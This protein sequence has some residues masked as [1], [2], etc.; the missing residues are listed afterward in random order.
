[1][2][3]EHTPRGSV[4]LPTA[5]LLEVSGLTV[6]FRNDVRA[7]GGP[8]RAVRGVG[9]R[10]AA[11]Q[12]MAVVGPSGS[13]KSVTASALIGLVPGAAEVEG[14]VR[15]D[16]QELLHLSDREL[17]RIRGRR[18]GMVFQ[19]PLAALNP[20]IP[21]GR[22]IAEAVRLHRTTTRKEARE[23]AVRL[24]DRV[25][26]PSAARRAGAFPH[27]FSGGMR[28]RAAIAMAIAGGPELL[29]ADEPTSALD[30]TVQA[31]LLHLLDSLRADTGCALLMITHDLGVVA[32]SCDRIA[33]MRD[34][35]LVQQ[36]E[37]ATLLAAASPPDGELGELLTA[38]RQMAR[39]R[40]AG[41]R[42]RT[43]APDVLR[44]EGLRREYPARGLA[45]AGRRDGVR[46][47]DGVSFTVAEGRALALLGESG[48]GK[49]TVLREI[50]GLRPPQAGRVEVL[51]HDLATLNRSDRSA[52]RRRMQLVFQDP[53]SSLDPLMTVADL[54]GEPLALGGEPAEAR[55]RRVAE[56][57]DLVELEQAVA[58]ARPGRLSGGQR[59]RVAIAR[60]LATRPRLLLLDEPVS[61]LDAPLRAGVMDL[62]DRLRG[63]LGLAYVLVSH[64]VHLVRRCADDVAV[65]YRGRL[66]EHG[67]TAAVLSRPRHPYTRALV[68]AALGTDPHTERHRGR[69]LLVEDTT[70]P[71]IGGTGCAFRPRCP[72]LTDLDSGSRRLCAERDPSPPR[73]HCPPRP[74]ATEWTAACHHTAHVAAAPAATGPTPRP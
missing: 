51:G 59:Q 14:S 64:D 42:P 39:P 29:I 58:R 17:S 27:E 31:Q 9:L 20:V 73:G 22:Q 45:V 2:E 63:E 74:D 52:L 70:I 43:S 35:A 28:Q 55:G 16:G 57:L 50:M 47:V 8:R 69:V 26:I 60:A 12:A 25:G 68:D 32:R 4:P 33:V 1:M 56:L 21:V 38:T 65:L 5:P 54:I 10:L 3:T 49:T 41:P 24:L 48:S 13:G 7:G 53:S 36:G 23:E 44:V 46:A 11:G 72:L 66:V 34:G 67:P 40:P 30:T 62:L 18:V 71:T 6:T 19:D 61:A 37:V 15:F